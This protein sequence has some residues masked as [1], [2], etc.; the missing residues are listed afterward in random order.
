[1]RQTTRHE[2]MRHDEQHWAHRCTPDES[3]A[4]RIAAK[5]A[6]VRLHPPDQWHTLAH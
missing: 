1:M 5:G 6:D 4:V 3:D 2:A